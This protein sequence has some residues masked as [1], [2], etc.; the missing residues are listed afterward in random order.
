MLHASS[1]MTDEK[2]T[3]RKRNCRLRFD[4]C[5]R[6]R[7]G[8]GE[9]GSAPDCASF[10]DEAGRGGGGKERGQ[11]SIVS[12]SMTVMFLKPTAVVRK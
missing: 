11:T 12:M 5:S 4:T 7:R 9:G 8:M 3:D 10:E 6:M 2:G 1:D